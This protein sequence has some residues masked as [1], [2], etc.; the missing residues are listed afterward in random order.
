MQ[1]RSKRRRRR[2]SRGERTREPGWR[3]LRGERG[4]VLVVLS[5]EQ[6]GGGHG[7]FAME[8]DGR[9][10]PVRMVEVRTG[11]ERLDGVVLGSRG[12]RGRKDVVVSLVLLLLLLGSLKSCR[13]TDGRGRERKRRQG[14]GEGRERKRKKRK[15]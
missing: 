1:K 14:G 12:R 9:K 3:R 7:V 2:G 15:S 11:G 6:R 5:S 4:R 8:K 13:R 10:L